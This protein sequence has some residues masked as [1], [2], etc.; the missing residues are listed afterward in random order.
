MARLPVVTYEQVAAVAN[1]LYAAGNKDPGT[2]AVREELLKRAAG[3]PTGSPNTIQRHLDEWRQKERPVEQQEFAALPDDLARTV[4]GALNSAAAVGRA[5]VESRLQQV[6][7][8][9]RELAEAGEGAEARFE[10]VSQELA[11]RTSERDSVRGQLTQRNGEVEELKA[12]L[13]AA[14]ERVAAL[15]ATINAAKTEAQEASGRVDEI[16]VSTDKQLA[17]M[18]I[19]RDEARAGHAEADRRAVAAEKESVAAAARLEG[20]RAAKAALEAQVAELKAS[21]AALQPDA[22]RAGAATAELVGL[23]RE[24]DRADKTIIMLRDLVPKTEGGDGAVQPGA[25]GQGA[26]GKRGG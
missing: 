25:G 5:K 18:R 10:D 22:A 21:V 24:I 4:L 20:E 17:Q 1:A 6:Q 23:R 3:G 13:A 11:S 26:A 8:E 16:R 15:E 9:L 19:E 12:A 2:K 7:A 14:T